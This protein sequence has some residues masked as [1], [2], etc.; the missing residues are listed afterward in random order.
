MYII[1]I[2]QFTQGDFSLSLSFSLSP[3][4]ITIWLTGRK[5]PSYLLTYLLSLLSDILLPYLL[6]VC[7]YIYN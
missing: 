3:P 7:L 1:I 6:V 2:I 5:T 4:D